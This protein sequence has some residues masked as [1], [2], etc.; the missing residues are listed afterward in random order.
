[1]RNAVSEIEAAQ[2][3]CARQ[4]GQSLDDI[5]RFFQRKKS[6]V[7]RVFLRNVETGNFKRRPGQ[8]RKNVTT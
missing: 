2:I 1:M 5:A 8:G 7:S 3:V 6:V 4:M